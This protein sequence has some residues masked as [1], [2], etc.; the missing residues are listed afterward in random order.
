VSAARIE[1]STGALDQLRAI[2]AWWNLN[3]PSAPD[4][5]H[6]ELAA[7]VEMLRQSPL[8]AKAY[9]FPA[10]PGLRRTLMQRTR[11]HV[12]FTYHEESALIFVHAVWHASRGHGPRL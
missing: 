7:T 6:E 12:Y 8:A 9:E 1:F 2:Q 11:Y 3:R 10:I 4:L 5:F